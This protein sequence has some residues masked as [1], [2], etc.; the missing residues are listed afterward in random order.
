MVIVLLLFSC[1]TPNDNNIT[2]DP[3]PSKTIDAQRD[4]LSV[5][6][7]NE[8][9]A[10]IDY[11]VRSRTTSEERSMTRNYLISVFSQ[12][13]LKPMEHVYKEANKNPFVNLL[14]DPFEGANVYATINS[15]TNSDAFVVLGAHY[16]T[17]RNCPGANDNAS[18]IAVLYSVAKKLTQIPVR[19]R[20]VMIV[21]FD[22]EEE[23]LIGSR[24]FAKYLKKQDYNIHSVHTLDQIGWDEDLD[25]GIEIELPTPEL[26]ELYMKHAKAF[27]I[28]IYVSEVN[29]TDHQ[30]FRDLGY[31]NAVGIT[32][33]YVQGDTTPY[34][35]TVKDTFDTLNLEYIES[36]SNFI[37]EVINELIA[38]D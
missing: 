2:I 12:L 28:P 25:K 16:D 24:A 22:Q 13:G 10:E 4:I 3:L 19:N 14:V 5:L 8:A 26:E 30:S 17:A 35:D 31:N 27:G 18:A 36:C 34:K 23:G 20:N 32:E 7:G 29:S 37:F 21:F 15:T 38:R 9:I 1:N 11:T 6:T 33:E